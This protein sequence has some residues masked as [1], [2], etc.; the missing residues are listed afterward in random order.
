MNP[1][2]LVGNAQLVASP[3]HLGV[4]GDSSKGGLHVSNQCCQTMKVGETPLSSGF[5]SPDTAF[6]LSDAHVTA[7]LQCL[8]AVEQNNPRLLAQ[9]DTS[10]VS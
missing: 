9:I 10:M 2:L 5:L 7:M 4:R 6:L 8:E 1:F 3:R